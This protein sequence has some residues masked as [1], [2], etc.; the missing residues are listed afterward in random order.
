MKPLRFRLSLLLISLFA[1]FIAGC[2]SAGPGASGRLPDSYRIYI[3]TFTDRQSKG[4][5]L[6]SM[7]TRTGKLSDPQLVAEAKSPSFLA[8]HPNRR[9]I[10]S[11][12]EVQR[13]DG[14][15]GTS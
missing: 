5:Y 15:P 4:I 14:K 6:V 9:F 13:V 7:D 10:Y 1:S 11:V 8:L 12:N 3:G 2:Q